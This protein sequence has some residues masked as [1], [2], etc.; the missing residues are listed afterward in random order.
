M[1][2]AERLSAQRT[3][4]RGDLETCEALL[5]IGISKIGNNASLNESASIV[6]V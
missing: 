3:E 5:L 6:E 1:D 2:T 4:W